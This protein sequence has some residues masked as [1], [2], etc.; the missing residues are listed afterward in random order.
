MAARKGRSV[1]ILLDGVVVAGVRTRSITIDN[2]AI[3]VT[4]DESNGFR[5]LIDA[6]GERDIKA[7]VEGLT[8]DNDLLNAAAAG[9]ALIRYYDI[10]LYPD[11][12]LSGDFRISNIQLGTEYNDAVA[13]TA[14]LDGTGIFY[15]FG[16]DQH[17]VWE[18]DSLFWQ[19]R[20][21]VWA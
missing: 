19:S 11:F 12:T 18:S 1:K 6:S 3:D 8:K 13:F 9:A 7:S 2:L 15:R 16:P 10:Q 17:M 14:Q 5:E 20:R 21:M 4:T